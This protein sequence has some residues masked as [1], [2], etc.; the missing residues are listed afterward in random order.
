MAGADPFA[1]LVRLY[2]G[3]ARKGPGSEACTRRALAACGPLGEDPRILDLGCGAGAATR[4]LAMETGG[5][6]AA[7]DLAE[8]FLAEL[9][10]VAAT[11]GLDDRIIT[12]CADFSRPPFADAYFDLLWSE[13]A[14]YHLGWGAGLRA[15]RRLLKPGGCLAATEAVWLV[16]DPPA[17]ARNAWSTWYP[18][19]AGIEANAQAA[20]EL[21]FEV[22]ETFPLPSEAWEEYY[23]PLEVRLGDPAF[24]GHP[25]LAETIDECRQEIDLCRACGHSYG[26]AFFVLRKPA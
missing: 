17:P 15:W 20:R 25:E 8:P 16:E 10:A 21:G 23:A 3:L 7:L 2:G 12:V 14:I 13:G 24:A 5:R 6:V 19:M 11:E 9:R 26:Y 22:V 4:V 1:A 18:A